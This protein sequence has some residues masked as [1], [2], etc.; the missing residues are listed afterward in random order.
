MDIP[1]FIDSGIWSWVVIPVL[2]FLARIVDV[3]IGTIRV[4]F[5][6]KG[7]K[8]IAPVLGF[9]EVIIWLL[10]IGQIVQNLT[11]WVSYLAYGAG[12]ATG[13]Y[14]GMLIENRLSLGL[15]IVRIITKQNPEAL[16]EKLKEKKYGIT[17]IDAKGVK[18]D[19]KIIFTVIQRANLKDIVGDI[20]TCSPD[21]FYSVEDV[22]F[23]K[24]GMFPDKN[25]YKK[26]FFKKTALSPD[27][28]KRKGK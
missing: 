16:I 1:S 12:F 20:T 11:N 22:R 9:F 25:L 6:S 5:I 17:M 14:V 13:T 21:A 15:L 4:I 24:E 7:I 28:T 18:G 2:I 26:L 27:K 3:S 23:A 19:V 10:A 8:Y